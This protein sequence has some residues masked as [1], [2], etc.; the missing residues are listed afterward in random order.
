MT[1]LV[2]RNEFKFLFT[3]FTVYKTDCN[4]DDDDG[5]EKGNEIQEIK[6]F[7]KI[8]TLSLLRLHEWCVWYTCYVCAKHSRRKSI[9]LL[10]YRVVEDGTRQI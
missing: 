2:I 8:E 5:K 1:E 4:H 9:C 6:N 7:D 10:Y 3:V